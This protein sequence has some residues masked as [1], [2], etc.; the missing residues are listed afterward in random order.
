[1]GSPSDEGSSGWLGSAG[2]R[3]K[4][5][6]LG[7]LLV[8]ACTR[9]PT[10]TP[11]GALDIVVESDLSV[12]KDIDHITLD[13]TQ[14]DSS[15][16]HVDRD[17]GPGALLIPAVFEVQATTDALPVTVHA[18]AFETGVPRIERDAVTPI[19]TDRTGVLRLALDYLCIGTA[20]GQADGGVESTCPAG[21][22]CV[23]GACAT[24]VIPPSSI[25]TAM[26]ASDAGP[27]PPVDAV[28]LPGLGV[29]GGASGGCFDVGTCFASAM[30][31]VIDTAACTLHL[32]E[33]TSLATVN[34][35]LQFPPGGTGICGPTACWVTLTGWTAN[36]GQLALAPSACA[37][38]ETQGGTIV[39]SD[40]CTTQD[41]SMPPCGPWSSV[42]V[43]APQPGPPSTEPIA[44]S[45]AGPATQSCG[46]CGTQSRPCVDGL[47][48][49]WSACAGEG[50]CQAGSTED[51][52]VGGFA[53]MRR[54][55]PLGQL[56]LPER[57]ALLRGPRQLR[58]GHRH[59]HLRFVRQRLH[60]ASQRQRTDHL[61]FR[62]LRVPVHVL[63]GGIWRLQR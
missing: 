34:V 8:A 42:T 57:P 58:L 24:N 45:C 31:A 43:V 40:A 36:N 32:P 2:A 37:A 29:D 25:P 55:V 52:G 17:I 46:L 53:G 30:P 16:L 14:G 48:G 1:M 61:L 44:T 51:C 54:L 26:A 18:V 21:A 15:R 23:L 9:S 11:S 38:A 20:E 22:T 19:P 35:A 27:L 59:A 7:A 41:P 13:V 49:A 39:V 12:P 50:V 63:H 60:R 33:G 56:R 47:W 28:N 3:L 6:V 5:C 10:G 4:G 62:S